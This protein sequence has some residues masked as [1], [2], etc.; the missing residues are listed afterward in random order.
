M[1]SVAVIGQS[2]IAVATSFVEAFIQGDSTA[3]HS[4]DEHVIEPIKLRCGEIVDN[5]GFTIHGEIPTGRAYG[6]WT[7]RWVWT[8]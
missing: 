2:G 8:N 7:V 5:T 6:Q 4:A 1:A 3:D